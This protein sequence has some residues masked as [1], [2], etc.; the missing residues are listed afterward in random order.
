MPRVRAVLIISSFAMLV[1]AGIYIFYHSILPGL[2]YNTRNAELMVP[3]TGCQVVENK[4]Y[5]ADLLQQIN[6][7]RYNQGLPKL[8]FD[9]R[10]YQA[11]EMHNWDMSC[12]H[13][14]SHTNL[15]GQS[16]YD[17]IK[18][19]GYIYSGAAEVIYTGSNQT[20]AP[21][22]AL[23]AWLNNSGCKAH[24]L[25]PAFTQ[26]GIGAVTSQDSPNNG[27]FTVVFADPAH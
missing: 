23:K 9:P 10:L 24:L 18:A 26:V 15:A 13:F 8:S 4:G 14:F 3:L 17:R 6:A 1:S 19:Q 5:E 25:D 20:N 16:I 7:E 12:K 11:A 2:N 21:R 27:Y 22:E